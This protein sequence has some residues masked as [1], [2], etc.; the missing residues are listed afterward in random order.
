MNEKVIGYILL[1][2]AL[3]IL[4]IGQKCQIWLLDRVNRKSAFIDMHVGIATNVMGIFEKATIFS[5]SCNCLLP[6]IIKYFVMKDALI[7]I[8]IVNHTNC[9][10]LL[11]LGML[12]W[13]FSILSCH[14]T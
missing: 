8:F 2:H 6:T 14:V 12:W 11:N 3:D 4:I 7:P 1:T 9:D 13:H 5:A 10:K